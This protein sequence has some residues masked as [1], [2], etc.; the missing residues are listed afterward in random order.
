MTA[1]DESGLSRH[2]FSDRL[3]DRFWRKLTFCYGLR[4]NPLAAQTANI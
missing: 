3:N 4:S 1:I 2:R